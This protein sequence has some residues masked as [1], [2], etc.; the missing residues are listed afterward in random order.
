MCGIAGLFNPVDPLPQGGKAAVERMAFAM[1]HRGPDAEGYFIDEYAALGHRRLSIIDLSTG[2]QPMFGCNRDHVLVF[3]GEIYNF[4]DLRHELEIK[5]YP[6]RTK[7]DTEV[8]LAGYEHWGDEVVGKLRGMFAFVLYDARKRR[9]LAARDP[10][11]KKPFYY[12]LSANGTLYFSSDMG[13]LAAS[14]ALDGR[15][16]ED[17]LQLY[18]YLGYI[19]APYSI[20]SCVRKLPAGHVLRYDAQQLQCAKYWDIELECIDSRDETQCLENLANLLDVAVARR[21]IADVP[22]GALLSSGI[23]SNLV[24]STMTRLSSSPVQTYTA[25]FNGKA[26]LTGTKDERQLAAEAAQTYGTQHES[27]NIDANIGSTLAPLIPF[28]GEPFADSSIIPTYLVCQ[29]ARQKVT[30]ALTGDG[31]DEPFG[32]YSFRY[33][34]HLF[35]DR[36]RKTIPSTLLTTTSRLLAQVWPASSRLPKYL[37]L[38]TIFR[39]LAATAAESFL[40]DQAISS[41]NR[42]P[43][44]IGKGKPYELPL[45]LVM[46]LYKKAENRDELTRMLYVDARLYMTED[47]LV[48]TDRM[49]MANSLEIRSPLLDQEIVQF[50]FALPS[51]MKIKNRRCKYLLRELARS[52]TASHI[53]NQPKTGFSIPIDNYLRTEWSRLFFDS[54]FDSNLPLK[55]L[56]DMR[57]VMHLW[58]GFLKGNNRY[59][60]FLWAVFILALWLREFH[61]RQQFNSFPLPAGSQ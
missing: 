21:M 9:I 30:V 40:M 19:P 36:L 59:L 5:G 18:L 45:Q 31:G 43:L 38:S 20:Y 28:L 3:N 24:V 8:I 32:G 1:A 7:S 11:G 34:P 52:R 12:H 15:I 23:D 57:H 58:S 47:V 17:A 22:L 44:L 61:H 53:I 51:E 4:L 13:S 2:Q 55:E 39:N 48:K 42:L 10:I 26:V 14:G 29:A 35:E 46:D 54:V 33:L 37:R 16:S 41:D 49:S 60:Q 6:F 27:I 56:V 50:A 25:G